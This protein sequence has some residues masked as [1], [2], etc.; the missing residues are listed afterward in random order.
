M[1]RQLFNWILLPQLR[2]SLASTTATSLTLHV[3]EGLGIQLGVHQDYTAGCLNRP[4]HGTK[5]GQQNWTYF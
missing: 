1:Y 5:H 3:G 2:A 4:P